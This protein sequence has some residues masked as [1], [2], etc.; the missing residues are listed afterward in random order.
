MIPPSS[1]DI[2]HPETAAVRWNPGFPNPALVEFHG[3][4]LTSEQRHEP[5][6]CSPTRASGA[7]LAA[8]SD[9]DTVVWLHQRIMSLQRERES[10]WQKI[11]KLLPGMS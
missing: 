4:L 1:L 6:L 9:R 8:N 5:G 7:G 3:S 10:R 2:Q 11:L